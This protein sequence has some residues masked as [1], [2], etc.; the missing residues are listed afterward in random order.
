MTAPLPS[1]FIE[2]GKGNNVNGGDNVN[3]EKFVD[4][5]DSFCILT[6]DKYLTRKRILT[7]NAMRSNNRDDLLR[8]S[9]NLKISI[10]WRPINN[11]DEYLW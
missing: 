4:A 9:F 11:P 1:R 8:L 10:F 6:S 7:R 3:E 5:I 2:M